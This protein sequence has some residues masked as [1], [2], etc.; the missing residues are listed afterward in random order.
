MGRVLFFPEWHDGPKG[1][2]CM[3][4]IYH[5]FFRL[6]REM[7][8]VFDRAAWKVFLTVLSFLKK[9]IW[10]A[11]VPHG[12]GVS[13]RFIGPYTKREETP[14]T[15]SSIVPTPNISLPERSSSPGVPRLRRNTYYPD[16]LKRVS[17]YLW[18]TTFFS[19]MFESPPL[20]PLYSSLGLFDY[21]LL[22]HTQRTPPTV[23]GERGRFIIQAEC[24][25]LEPTA[26]SLSLLARSGSA[27]PLWVTHTHQRQKSPM[28]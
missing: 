11:I 6:A 20:S 18:G 8:I 10:R 3:H 19:F 9:E 26:D 5:N 15:I 27:S 1:P 2:M 21:S 14:F 16:L 7:L 22:F 23:E 28:C 17:H 13:I 24:R 12:G 25:I 4:V